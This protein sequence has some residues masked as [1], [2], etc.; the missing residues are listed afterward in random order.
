MGHIKTGHIKYACDVGAPPEVAFTY[1]DNHRF[2]PHW[3]FGISAF[4]PAGE[5]SHGPGTRY[6]ARVGVGP[7]HRTME[8]EITEYRP[9]VVIGYSMRRRRSR[10]VTAEPPAALATL[11]LRFDPLGYG[12]SVLTSEAD[13]RRGTGLPARL[14]TRAIELI[15]RTMMHRSESRLR[16]EIEQFHGANT[17]GRL[18]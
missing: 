4:E 5:S 12:R 17:V 14:A 10:R 18:A 15:I 13:Y 7:W 3:M 1:T 8:C 16:R 2:V 11:T 6:N 9:N